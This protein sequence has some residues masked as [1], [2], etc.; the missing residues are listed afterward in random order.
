MKII[1]VGGGPAGV[2]AALRARELGADVTL[3]ESA[4]LGG[5]CFN[6]G[7]APMRALARAARLRADAAA[8]SIFG[9]DGAA[10]RV[11]FK[12]AIAN[13]NRIA[14]Y[15]NEVTHLTARVRET[16]VDVVDNAG[17]AHFVD[18][19][20][21]AIAD[22]RQFTGDRIVLTVGGHPRK[23][24]I[25]GGELALSFRDLWTMEA[26]PKRVTVVG[27]SATGCQLASILLDFGAQVDLI[28]ATDRLAPSCDVD[29]SRGLEAAFVARG[30]N[31]LTSVRSE[32]IVAKS[33]RFGVVSSVAGIGNRSRPMPYS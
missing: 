8:F 17:P 19:L 23:L 28:Q 32:E 7:P 25:P 30:M 4:H 14:A 3:L 10:P 15:A 31:V 13:A 26:L 29:V 11:D 21:L 12:A 2:V 24:P 20:T 5:T 1:V 16:G 27:G 22:G 6:E 18:R 33:D 9:L